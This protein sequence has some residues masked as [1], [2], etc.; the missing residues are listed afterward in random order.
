MAESTKIAKRRRV[1]VH[2]R[3]IFSG[4]NALVRTTKRIKALVDGNRASLKPL[5]NDMTEQQVMDILRHLLDRRIFESEARAKVEF[6]DLF[7]PPSVRD[8]QRQAFEDD[9]ARSTEEAWDSIA[10]CQKGSGSNSDQHGAPQKEPPKK[11][12]DPP[13]GHDEPPKKHA[14]HGEPPNEHGEPRKEHGEPPKKHD[15]PPKV[16][17]EPVKSVN[18][19]EKVEPLARTSWLQPNNYSHIASNLLTLS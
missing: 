11:H 12:T 17:D 6:P 14:E 9:A 10:S 13:K 15:E 2:C 1:Y 4:D 16:H 3:P 19:G 18:G 7:R 8:T 5:L